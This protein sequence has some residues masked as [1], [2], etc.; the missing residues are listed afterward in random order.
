MACSINPHSHPHGAPLLR[1]PLPSC[2]HRLFLIAITHV[3]SCGELPA[4]APP[5]VHQLAASRL[6]TTAS[7]CHPLV[8]SIAALLLPPLTATAVFQFAVAAARVLMWRRWERLARQAAMPRSRAA[9]AAATVV[10]AER[11]AA[12]EL[13]GS[14]HDSGKVEEPANASADT[15]SPGGAPAAAADVQA[16][17]A[18]WQAEQGAAA[19]VPAGA[20]L[21]AAVGGSRLRP[22]SLQKLK[23]TARFVWK[24][25]PADI[26]E[27]GITGW[28]MELGICLVQA[29]WPNL[30]AQASCTWACHNVLDSRAAPGRRACCRT[31]TATLQALPAVLQC[32]LRSSSRYPRDACP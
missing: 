10:A 4:Q 24:F 26:Y 25:Q 29:L 18:A 13:P 6:P 22:R 28:L 21:P 7:T 15:R 20:S 30:G 11:E 27:W 8:P 23:S 17:A 5:C 1:Q 2:I 9:L 14:K 31:R 3:G 19:S 12:A 32:L 16:A